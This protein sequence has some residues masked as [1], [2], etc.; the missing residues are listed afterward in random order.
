MFHI[1]RQSVAI[2]L[3]MTLLLG[4]IYPLV[5][6]GLAQVVFPHQ[7]NGSVIIR[8]EKAVGSELIGQVFSEPRYFWGRPSATA[9]VPYDAAHSGGSNHGP[10]NPR[11]LSDV[12][13]RAERLR[14]M[15]PTRQPGAPVDLVTASA[16]GL[17]PDISPAGAEHQVPRVAMARG[18]PEAK[19]RELVQRFTTKPQFGLLGPPRVNVLQ[20]NLALDELAG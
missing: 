12:R 2:L 6:T 17:D 1:I 18:L 8:N 10:L 13:A 7:A 14:S 3:V 4:V 19:V 11:L 16:S 20:L 15:D 9:P 5:V